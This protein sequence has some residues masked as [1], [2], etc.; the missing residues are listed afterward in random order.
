MLL[1]TQVAIPFKGDGI[2]GEGEKG[3]AEWDVLG[4]PCRPL[5]ISS[6]HLQTGWTDLINGGVSVFNSSTGVNLC[7]SYAD[8]T[9]ILLQNPIY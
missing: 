9:R 4:I 2:T 1:V 3:N 5:P 6:D 8:I 7:Y